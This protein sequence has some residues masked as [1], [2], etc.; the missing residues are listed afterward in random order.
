MAIQFATAEYK[1]TEGYANE[2]WRHYIDATATLNRWNEDV[3]ARS[4]T[5]LF[6]Q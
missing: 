4:R 2:Q 5:F 3:F 6:G 1:R